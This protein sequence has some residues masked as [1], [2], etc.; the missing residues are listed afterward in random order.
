[1]TPPHQ[2]HLLCLGRAWRGGCIQL[3]RC[4]Y[5]VQ[6]AGETLPR[7]VGDLPGAFSLRCGPAGHREQHGIL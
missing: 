2:R 4:W 6:Q 5:G 3:V 7:G 1:M